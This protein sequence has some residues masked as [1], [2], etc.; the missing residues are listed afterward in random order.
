MR[1]CLLCLV[2]VVAVSCATRSADEPASV[3]RHAYTADEALQWLVDGN[4]RFATRNF[5]RPHQTQARALE[6]AKRQDPFAIILSCSDSRVPTEL[7]FDQGLG[8]LFVIRVAGNIVAEGGLASIEYGVKYL[9]IPLIV[10]LGHERCGAVEAALSDK[11][12]RG[13][14]PYL[15]NKMHG[16]IEKLK[17]KGAPA[18]DEAIANNVRNSVQLVKAAKPIVNALVDAGKVKVVGAVYDLDTGTI[19]LID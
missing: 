3:H 2:W 11:S 1:I 4:Q 8:D 9:N 19:Q 10:V 18:L 5:A 13:H 6:Q 14:L 17:T 7:V 16:V 15:M 12:F